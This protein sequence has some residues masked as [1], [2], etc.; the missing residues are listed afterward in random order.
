MKIVKN[1]FKYIA[2]GI[3]AL[4]LALSC[5]V[6]VTTGILKQDYANIF[7]YT[8]FQVKTGSMTGS[9]DVGDIV[10][11]NL[12]DNYDSGDIITYQTNGSFVT[13][14]LVKDLGSK[15]ITKGDVNNVEDDPVNKDQVV[16]KVTVIIST[17]LLLQLLGLFIIIAIFITL[18]NFDTIFKKWIFQTEESPKKKKHKKVRSDSI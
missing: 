7:G 10:I 1:I 12:T 3:L 18:V 2:Y 8:Y 6:V 11:V 9:I 17:S 16:G 13:H 4:F 5:Y 15:V 14:R